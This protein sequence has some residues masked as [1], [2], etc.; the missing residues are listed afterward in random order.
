MV[1]ARRWTKGTYSWEQA[2]GGVSEGLSR[3][4]EIVIR[5]F[6]TIHVELRA[7]MRNN[8]G[9]KVREARVM[10][11]IC[12]TL[13]EGGGVVVGFLYVEVWVLDRRTAQMAR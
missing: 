11:F 4:M 13:W 12:E 8:Q 1:I 3:T 2:F 7:G 10:R 6:C 5:E 9:G